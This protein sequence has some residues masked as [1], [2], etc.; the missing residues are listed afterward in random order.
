MHAVRYH[1]FTII[2]CIFGFL[3]CWLNGYL[4]LCFRMLK[5]SN[6]TFH[7]RVSLFFF[8]YSL[9]LNA[10]LYTNNILAAN[11]FVERFGII[12]YKLITVIENNEKWID[13]NVRWYGIKTVQY[14]ESALIATPFK[15]RR[16]WEVNL[17]SNECNYSSFCI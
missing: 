16:T 4:N 2:V 5:Q 1:L 15:W 11:M 13:W 14:K 12:I 9:E 3:S 7:I 10:T 17:C 6:N 8:N